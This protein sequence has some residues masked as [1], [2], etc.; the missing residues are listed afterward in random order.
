MTEKMTA[1]QHA[2]HIYAEA[3]R[4]L[5]RFYD[6]ERDYDAIVDAT[7]KKI[8]GKK[9]DELSDRDKRTVR[10][11]ASTEKLLEEAAGRCVY[12]RDRAHMLA[13]FYLMTRDR[14]ELEEY[15]EIAINGTGR[16]WVEP[17]T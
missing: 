17:T 7:A 15:R 10:H 12:A 13:T 9:F 2:A 6:A 5:K 11:A 16:P 8:S 14:Q 4:S 3:L 1:G